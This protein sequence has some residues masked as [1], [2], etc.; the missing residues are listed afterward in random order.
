MKQQL[1]YFERAMDWLGYLEL[2]SR[3]VTDLTHRQAKVR[4]NSIRFLSY[5]IPFVRF[6]EKGYYIEALRE[7]SQ[8]DKAKTVR[9]AA[10]KALEALKGK[11]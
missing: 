9:N 8:K 7:I 5:L 1:D 2:A 10:Q 6:P 4:K 11:K 3:V